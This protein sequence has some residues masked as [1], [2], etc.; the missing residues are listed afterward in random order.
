MEGKMKTVWMYAG[1]G[2][3]K[4]GMGRDIYEEFEDYRAVVDMSEDF[5]PLVELMH[6]GALEELSRTENTQ[7]CMA[8]FAAGVTNVLTK[9]GLRPDAVCGLSLG[10]YGALYAAG[11]FGAEEYVKLT[12]FRGQK[13]ME[14]AKGHDCSMSAVL[15]LESKVV[16]EGCEAA[17]D[18]GF[19]TLAN[20][21]CPG[22][23]V[24][25]GDEPAVAK[26]EAYLKE[27]GAKRCIRLNVSGPFHTKYMKPA[28]DAL[29]ER[30]SAMELGRPGIPVVMNV[31]G[32]YLK[33]DENIA[34]LLERQVQNSVRFEGSLRRLL[35][36]GADTFV[37]I[38]P[39]TALSGF[40]KKTA[41]AMGKEVSVVGI[42]TAADLH[43]VLGE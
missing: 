20:Y 35:A 3:Q 34:G 11:V 8:L 40:L 37:E 16:E 39:G 1:Q 43:K 25:C 29:R 2:S 38:G 12:A 10:E 42:E 13:M 41:K 15:G 5:T 9:R 27:H 31:T 22:Q 21:N 7:P 33:D 17:G 6:N 19:I 26:A 14:A 32:D 24:I 23:Y 4:A 18:A 36:D 28:G 30:F